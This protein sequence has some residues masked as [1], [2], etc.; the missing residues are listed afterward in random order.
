MNLSREEMGK[1]IERLVLTSD[2]NPKNILT[3]EQMREK[4]DLSAEEFRYV[5]L[6]ERENRAESFLAYVR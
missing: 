3:P 5:F 4:I 1:A 2:I 6:I